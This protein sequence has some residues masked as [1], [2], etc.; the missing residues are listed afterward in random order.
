[1][2]I[3]DHISKYLE[4]IFGFKILKLFDADRGWKNSDPGSG[5]NIPDPHHWFRKS[6]LIIYNTDQTFSLNEAPDRDFRDLTSTFQVCRHKRLKIF[7][8][9]YQQATGEA[10]NK[11]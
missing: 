11:L 1:M 10:Q 2:N 8:L 5:I 3:P 9:H 4:T 6:A 7:L